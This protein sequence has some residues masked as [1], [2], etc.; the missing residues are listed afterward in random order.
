[1]RKLKLSL[2]K[3]IISDLEAKQ[4]NGGAD[5][6]TRDNNCVATTDIS[7]PPYC[8]PKPTQM[9]YCGANCN[10]YHN[11]HTCFSYESTCGSKQQ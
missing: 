6:A 7:K 8:D 11:L 1:M 2:K 5:G 10:T 3:E 9:S 4:I